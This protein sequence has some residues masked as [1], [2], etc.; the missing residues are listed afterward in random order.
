MCVLLL[1]VVEDD[2]THIHTYTESYII[3]THYVHTTYYHHKYFW[4][5]EGGGGGRGINRFL[6]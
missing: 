3:H 6:S 5:E 4:G 1:H 2:Y